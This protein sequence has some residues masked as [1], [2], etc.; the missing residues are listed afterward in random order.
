MSSFL[1]VFKYL[2]AINGV[3][4]EYIATKTEPAQ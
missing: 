2:F 1:D 3:Y 4:K